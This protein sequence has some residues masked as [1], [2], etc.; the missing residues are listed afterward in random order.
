MR[1]NSWGENSIWKK[2]S[3]KSYFG[4]DFFKFSAYRVLYWYKTLSQYLQGIPQSRLEEWMHSL[5]ANKMPKLNTTGEAYRETQLL[6]VCKNCNCSIHAHTK[7][8]II[9]LFDGTIYF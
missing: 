2:K 3:V 1:P 9:H 4:L 5:P 8:P 6:Q 7:G